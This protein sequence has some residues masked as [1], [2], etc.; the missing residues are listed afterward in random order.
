[1]NETSEQMRDLGRDV[2]AKRERVDRDLDE[3]REKLSPGALLD[4]ALGYLGTNTDE[5][6]T[7]ARVAGRNVAATVL[8]HPLPLLLIA[9]GVLWLALELSRGGGHRS[10]EPREAT[11]R[12]PLPPRAP[13]PPMSPTEVPAAAPQAP[14]PVAGPR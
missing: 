6:R 11:Q 12:P 4:E 9:G 2:E 13:A 8:E 7:E 5:V 3:L 1:M 10:P 14:P